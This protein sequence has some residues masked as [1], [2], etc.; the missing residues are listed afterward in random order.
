MSLDRSPQDV[1][2]AAGTLDAA[3]SQITLPS[4]HIFLRDKASWFEV[5]E[6]DGANRWDEWDSNDNM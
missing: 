6:S 5:P 1:S 4:H 2:V 3:E